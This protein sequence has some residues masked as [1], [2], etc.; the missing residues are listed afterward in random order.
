MLS[1]LLHFTLLG[2]LP[3]FLVS[4]H[5]LMSYLH[6]LPCFLF[7]QGFSSASV[8]CML[9]NPKGPNLILNLSNASFGG[10]LLVRRVITPTRQ[11]FVSMD[12]TFHKTILFFSFPQSTTQGKLST[13]ESPSTPL[14]VPSF[15]FYSGADDEGE[16]VL[17]VYYEKKKWLT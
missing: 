4:R 1:K 5:L 11:R 16:K 9:I 2:C 3:E 10:M 15:M 7:H 12:V 8:M 14:P 17:K 13:V 6:L